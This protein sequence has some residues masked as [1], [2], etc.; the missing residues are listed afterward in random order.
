MVVKLAPA[1][2]TVVPVPVIVAAFHVL[3]GP[4]SVSVPLPP[5]VAALSVNNGVLT[6]CT[7]MKFVV[8]P[9]SAIEL[10]FI[11]VLE[12]NVT[13]PAFTDSAPLNV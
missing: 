6:P 2:I 4:V 12:L 10:G 11:N 5:R 8:P 7:L 3:P 9:V 1:P 13:V